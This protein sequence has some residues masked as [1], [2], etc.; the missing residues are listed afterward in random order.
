MRVTVFVEDHW[1]IS[2]QPRHKLGVH[3]ML[4]DLV[5]VN[6]NK[7]INPQ[8]NT[9]WITTST[10]SEMSYCSQNSITYPVFSVYPAS[11]MTVSMTNKSNIPNVE[12]RG[13]SYK[14]LRY[15][16]WFLGPLK[17]SVCHMKTHEGIS[18]PW[19]LIFPA[20]STVHE[21]EWCQVLIR[22]FLSWA[23]S[24]LHKSRAFLQASSGLLDIV[25]PGSPTY[26]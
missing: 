26:I 24:F 19:R 14:M 12:E 18:R 2:C 22:A 21:L 20:I 11:A 4:S 10:W 15:M 5:T 3:A 17:I 25:W 8:V 16:E 6:R 7:E 9:A 1:R 13:K 23:T